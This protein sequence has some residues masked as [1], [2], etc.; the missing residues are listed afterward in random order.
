MK[1]RSQYERRKNFFGKWNIFVRTKEIYYKFTNN[2]QNYLHGIIDNLLK[3]MYNLFIMGE[4]VFLSE[5]IKIS[6]EKPKNGGN[7]W[8]KIK[9]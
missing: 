3:I 6:I 8:I 7:K 5:Q 2:L 4:K 9:Q 1:K